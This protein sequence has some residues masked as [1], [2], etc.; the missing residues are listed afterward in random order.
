MTCAAR[1]PQAAKSAVASTGLTPVERSIR[2]SR[3]KLAV[4]ATAFLDRPQ[5]LHFTLDAYLTVVNLSGDEPEAVCTLVSTLP[6]E[7]HEPARQALLNALDVPDVAVRR[8]SVEAL[9]A[10]AR[11][12]DATALL[13]AARRVR[14]LEGLVVKALRSI[15]DTRKV[16][17]VAQL[18]HRRLKWADDE[19]ID[20]FI[21]L[22]GHRA[23]PELVTALTTRFYPPARAGAARALARHDL[24][25]A[26]FTLRTR[27]MIDPNAD[28]RRAALR[29]LTLQ[30]LGSVGISSRLP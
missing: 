25:E 19:A 28:A 7:A 13:D 4:A 15:A 8:A 23:T 30:A 9:A 16:E 5:A 27:S 12:E 26:V 14:G 1:W 18:F 21:S 11:P 24:K 2:A 22:A 17:E 29:T 10:V 20:D 6:E 3:S